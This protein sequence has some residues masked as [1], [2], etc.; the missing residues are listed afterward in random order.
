M[1]TRAMENRAYTL[2]CNYVG[3][4]KRFHYCGQ[5]GAFHPTGKILAEGDTQTA[6]MLYA[7]VDMA[8]TIAQDDFL[9]YLNHR[10][11]DLYHPDLCR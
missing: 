9:N 3:T 11:P 2:Y 1:R 6:G 4:E 7:P 8:D 5:S 10:H